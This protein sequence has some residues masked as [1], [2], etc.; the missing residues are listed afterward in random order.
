MSRENSAGRAS[1]RREGPPSKSPASS[2]VASTS[3]V[4]ERLYEQHKDAVFRL[5]LRYGRGDVGW[6]EDVTHDVFLDLFDFVGRLEELHDLGG[7]FYRVATNRCLNK[8]KRQHWMGRP[9]VRFFLGEWRHEVPDPERIVIARGELQIAFEAVNALPPKERVVFFMRHVDG[10]DQVSI[11]RALR[12]SN[13]YVSKLLHRATRELEK[14]G[15][16]VNDER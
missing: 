10:M 13:G 1:M 3:L 8:L 15:W 6:A 12:F 2:N 7:W 16:E 14:A 5:A 11:A 4:I 9:V